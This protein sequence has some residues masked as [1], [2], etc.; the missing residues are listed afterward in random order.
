MAAVSSPSVMNHVMHASYEQVR[1]AIILITSF[2]FLVSYFIIYSFCQF[3]FCVLTK[4]CSG[5]CGI[6]Q[7][8]NCY[9]C[10]KTGGDMGNI[11]SQFQFSVPRVS[12]GICFISNMTNC[13]LLFSFFRTNRALWSGFTLRLLRSTQ[14]LQVINLD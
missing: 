10:D 8:E 7:N 14:L 6:H 2:S 11:V 4:A 9:C 12:S 5:N 13:K 1:I 3:L